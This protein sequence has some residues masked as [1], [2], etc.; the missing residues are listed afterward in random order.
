MIDVKR[1]KLI[2]DAVKQ[3]SEVIIQQG[4]HLILIVTDREPYPDALEDLSYLPQVALIIVELRDLVKL[5]VISQAKKKGIEID[6]NL[7]SRT[8]ESIIEKIGLRSKL[9]QWIA[10]MSEKGYLLSCEGFVDRTAQAC[11]FFINTIGKS[12][13]VRQSWEYGWK[14]KNLLPFNI[15]SEIIPDMGLD[16]LSKH[17]EIL[18]D[19][20]FLKEDGGKL[21]L[22]QHPTESCII[23][24][25]EYYGGSTAKHTL[26]QH[27]VFREAA[28]R[29]F[30]SF[31]DHMKR[32]LLLSDDH[33]NI[34]LLKPS[35]IKEIREE[36]IEVFEKKRS[37]LEQ[38]GGLSFAHILTWKKKGWQLISLAEIEQTVEEL[39]QEIAVADNQDVIRSRTFIV[40][41]LVEW[42]K[43]YVDKIILSLEKSKENVENLKSE[44]NNTKQKFDQVLSSIVKSTSLGSIKVELQ[45]LTEIEKEL[46]EIRQLSE[47]EKSQEELEK[48]IRPLA[49][50]KETEDDMRKERLWTDV[51][52]ELEERGDIRGYWTVAKYVLIKKKIEDVRKRIQEL[53]SMLDSL[54][55]TSQNLV[56]LVE[57]FLKL[58]S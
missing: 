26:A 6:K 36:V 11:R 4:V 25:L 20:G 47:T 21:L 58:F 15:K 56:N 16:E 13:T 1:E 34:R 55:K 54:N 29:I 50:D 17:V 43:Q 41:E 40:K 33:G 30:D 37:A 48:M 7:L 14:L 51:D 5:L 44:I 2:C 45:E 12:L 9:D 52:E 28:S 18:K 8:Y 49:G 39:L 24:L 23:E 3:Y 31:L 38:R 57:S 42:Y 22:Q 19:Y 35:E 27:F 10:R 46:E 53:D 32:K